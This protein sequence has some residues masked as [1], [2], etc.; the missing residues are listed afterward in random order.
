VPKVVG[1]TADQATQILKAAG[2]VNVKVVL[3]SG[4]DATSAD[5]SKVV[6]TVNPA[7]GASVAP[8]T[9]IVLTVGTSTTIG[10][11]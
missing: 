11:G 3:S 2:F 9:Q 10:N 7:E 8:S 6:V 1:Q 5:G 4:G